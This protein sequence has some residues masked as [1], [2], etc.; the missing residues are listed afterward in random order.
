MARRRDSALVLFREAE[1][2]P[3]P[4]KALPYPDHV[5]VVLLRFPEFV[6]PANPNIDCFRLS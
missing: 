5:S 2:F 4:V 3:T 6:R 1:E